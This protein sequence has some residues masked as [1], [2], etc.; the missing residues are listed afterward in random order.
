MSDSGSAAEVAI[1]VDIGG[2]KIAA[3]LVDA[4]GRVLLQHRSPTRP[5]ELFSDVETVCRELAGEARTRAHPVI[6]I[7]IGAKGAV[8]RLARRLVHSIYLGHGELPI[9][10]MLEGALGLPTWLEN[11]VHAATIGELLF[12]VGRIYEDFVLL[13]AGTGISI[14]IVAGGRLYRGGSGVAGEIGHV[15]MDQG[16][17][18]PCPCGLGGCMET[19]I[20]QDRTGRPAP[21]LKDA[22]DRGC[23]PGAAYDY[24]LAGLADV[25]TLL[26]PQAVVLAGGMLDA[27]STAAWLDRSARRL[28][29]AA[30]GSLAC[31]V[32][33]SAGSDA[34]LVGAGAL[35]FQATGHRSAPRHRSYL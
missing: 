30:N 28:V 15:S 10:E 16:G 9:G 2:T 25:L 3:G 26:N 34:G 24:I 35:A 19:M 5:V 31:I 11:D 18:F 14:G 20:V 27:P 4:T 12:G 32:P 13:N 7:G 17:E 29:P 23:S 33:A 8:D 6:G 21:R 22:V 1:G